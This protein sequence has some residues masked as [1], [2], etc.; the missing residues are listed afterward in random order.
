MASA[1]TP[2]ALTPEEGIALEKA[3]ASVNQKSYRAKQREL[4]GAQTYAQRQALQR[5]KLKAAQERKDELLRARQATAERKTRAFGLWVGG[6]SKA[7]VARE[8]GV[9]MNTVALWLKGMNRPEPE[10]LIPPDPIEEALDEV[11]TGAV[12][13]IRLAARDAENQALLEMAEA[14]DKPA[15]KYQAYIA[16]TAIKLLRDNMALIRGP[17]TI[18][19]LDRLDQLIRRN[20]GLNPKGG[21]SGGALNI[22]IS[23]LNNTR[24]SKGAIGHATVEA[25][26]A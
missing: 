11:T 20:L 9:N 13:D 14:H 2:V 16:A 22:D 10:I 1:P 18:Q 4:R 8:L 21:G 24:A 17:R 26:M 5:A 7:A 19:D 12:A 25:E 23:I 3:L 6:M 15:D